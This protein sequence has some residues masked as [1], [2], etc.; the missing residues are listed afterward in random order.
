MIDPDVEAA[1][2]RARAMFVRSRGFL[3]IIVALCALLIGV[4]AAE[5]KHDP[6]N[7]AVVEVSQ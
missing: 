6:H 7:S 5:R 4:L 2:G 3:I 1:R